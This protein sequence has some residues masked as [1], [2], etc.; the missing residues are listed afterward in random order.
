MQMN[1]ARKNVPDAETFGLLATGERTSSFVNALEGTVVDHLRTMKA[2]TTDLCAR[3]AEQAIARKRDLVVAE[4][5][6]PV[7]HLHAQR[8]NAGHGKRHSVFR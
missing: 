3:R 5:D 4:I 7:G 8:Q 1:V 6:E 2:M